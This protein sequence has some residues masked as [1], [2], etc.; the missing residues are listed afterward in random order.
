MKGPISA[1]SGEVRLDSPMSSMG[2]PPG[3]GPRVIH[4]TDVNYIKANEN[5]EQLNE[6]ALQSPTVGGRDGK[7]GRTHRSTRI[8]RTFW[9]G[10]LIFSIR[11]KN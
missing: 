1:V 7:T 3:F 11:K 2:A 10:G 6:V 5:I 8:T 4:S 9:W